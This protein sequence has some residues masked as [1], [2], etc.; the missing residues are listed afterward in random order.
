M[1]YQ[2]KWGVFNFLL[3]ILAAIPLIAS[4]G[5]IPSASELL[6]AASF[7][8]KRPL[9]ADS[10][11]ITATRKQGDAA[12]LVVKQKFALKISFNEDTYK[13]TG[14][15]SDTD[16]LDV[17]TKK[18]TSTTLYGIAE[19]SRSGNAWQTNFQFDNNIDY[20][21]WGSPKSAFQG[22]S[23]ISGSVEEKELLAKVQ[24]EKASIE[25]RQKAA[26]DLANAMDAERQALINQ[27]EKEKE[28]NWEKDFADL[29]QRI[30]QGS[31]D[32]RVAEI[33]KA[34]KTADTK[35]HERL[36]TFLSKHDDIDLRS[37]ALRMKIDKVGKLDGKRG[38]GNPNFEPMMNNPLTITSLNVGSGEINF[39]F[40]GGIREWKGLS[41]TIDTEKIKA[42]NNHCKIKSKLIEP[43]KLR[44]DI[45]CTPKSLSRNFVVF[46]PE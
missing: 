26:S 31:H 33:Q 35:L 36:M 43:N 37:I 4:A 41:G 45:L 23:V 44:G 12:S 22:K 21:A 1:S 38:N 46:L 39:D 24:S 15:I 42:K 20:A 16:V 32:Q 28:L 34:F 14:S 11:D 27:K 29:T 6:E 40:G 10:I 19:S 30:E 3:L 17:V 7:D 9:K 2:N 18:G 13:K 25:Q 5:D 8:L